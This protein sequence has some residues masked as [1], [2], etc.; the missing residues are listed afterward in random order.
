MR[1]RHLLASLIFLPAIC[2]A[3]DPAQMLRGKLEKGPGDKPVLRTSDGKLV[4][5][6]G[7]DDT[8]GV[9]K[10]AR[11]AGADFEVIGRSD[12]PDHFTINPIHTRAMFV[13]KDGKRLAVTYWCDVCAIRTY[14]PGICWCCRE[15]TALDLKEADKVSNK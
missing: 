8:V 3:A 4:Y 2:R 1:R 10:D 15:E 6:T 7:D 5:V 9:L 13:H 14:T 11:L 12:A